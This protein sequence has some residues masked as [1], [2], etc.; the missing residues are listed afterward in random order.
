VPVP[1]KLAW[2]DASAFATAAAQGFAARD[3]E[4]FTATAGA[5]A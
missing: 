3:L 5:K 1:R 2:K 4:R